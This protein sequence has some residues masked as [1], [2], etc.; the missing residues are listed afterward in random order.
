MSNDILFISAYKDI[1][2]EKWRHYQRSNKEYFSYFLNLT[3]NI[4]YNLVVYM[5]ADVFK[6]LLKYSKFPPNI[7][8][9]N[10]AQIK[11]TFFNKFLDIDRKVMNSDIYKNKI[12]IYRKN[13]PEHLYSEYNLINHSKINFVKDASIRFPNYEFY[14]WIDFGYVRTLDS[15]PKNINIARLPQKITYQ[16]LRIPDLNNKIGP[17]EML[18]TND[19]YFTG[20]PNIIHK[21]MVNEFEKKYEQKL[22]EFYEKNITDDD[23]NIILQIYYENPEMF[24]LLHNPEWFALYNMI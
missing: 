6:E 23:Q 1:G 7:C 17:N 15:L 21:S 12:P 10:L 24:N 20:S 4:K 16:C 2:R 13:N 19:V 5:E 11:D 14:S 22:L 18:K 8:F 9:I 3:N